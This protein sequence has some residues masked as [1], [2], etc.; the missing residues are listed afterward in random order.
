MIK[1]NPRKREEGT[2]SLVKIY[3]NDTPGEK[4]MKT[5]LEWSGWPPTSVVSSGASSA[6]VDA[7]TSS[8]L[9]KRNKIKPVSP[10][11]AIELETGSILTKK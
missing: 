11:Q 4:K 3:K 1:N 8:S 2:S 5:F 9:I 6:P 7:S 10:P